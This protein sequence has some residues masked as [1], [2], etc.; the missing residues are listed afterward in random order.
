MMARPPVAEMDFR[1]PRVALP[2]GEPALP[3]PA[4][5]LAAR[6]PTR[7]GADGERQR[8][9]GVLDRIG[10]FLLA[11]SAEVIPGCRFDP[12]RVR[13]FMK[14][15]RNRARGEGGRGADRAAR[16]L[17]RLTR[18]GEPETMFEGVNLLEL[19]RFVRWSEE[20]A[21]H[22]RRSDRAQPQEGDDE[23]LR[24]PPPGGRRAGLPG[25][26]LRR[27]PRGR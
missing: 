20:R 13:V 5:R 26:G 14:M 4:G 1:E 8:A 27:R 15:L 19:D 22:D 11:T 18:P 7:G 6:R 9:G 10:E 17:E 23:A 3:R 24:R 12:R 25:G 2:T 16:L 21:E